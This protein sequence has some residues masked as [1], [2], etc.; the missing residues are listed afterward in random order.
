MRTLRLGLKIRIS[1]FRYTIICILR[2]SADSAVC[3]ELFR[4]VQ[5][6]VQSCW[7]VYWE[8]CWELCWELLKNLLRAV[9]NSAESCWELCWE[10]LM[11]MLRCCAALAA[12][13]RALG[14]AVYIITRL[15]VRL[16][17]TNYANKSKLYKII[18]LGMTKTSHN[19]KSVIVNGRSTLSL[20]YT[21]LLGT[22]QQKE[23]EI[24]RA[25]TTKTS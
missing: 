22:V 2:A 12:A 16:E 25:Q 5:N 20:V 9:E 23:N 21:Q 18:Q 6:S 7:E 1:W 24:E 13:L 14:M 8:L 10:L 3:S 17:I 19:N 11:I 15:L 4:A